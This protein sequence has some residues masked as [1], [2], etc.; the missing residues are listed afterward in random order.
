MSDSNSSAS[1][2]E[3]SYEELDPDV[4]LML[5]VREDDAMAFEQ[6]I[7]QYQGR[8]IRIL[9]HVV[10]R[11]DIAEDLAQDVFL[12]VY[13]ARKTYKP[14]ARFSTWLFRIAN[15]VASNSIRDR[16][17]RKE[18]QVTS[19]DSSDSKAM[20]METMAM[21]SSGVMPARN[22]DKS[23]RAAMVRQAIEA[24]GERQRMAL[25]L[26]KFEGL[27]YQEIADTME[28]STKAVKSLLMRARVNL[29]VL[30]QP[31]LDEGQPPQGGS[32]EGDE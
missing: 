21:A 10:G 3:M 16:S 12:R 1:Q 31:Y 29:K 4:G 9:E 11:K 18:V 7:Q 25:L 28:L 14:G 19:G 20:R 26:S 17:R 32:T 5:R 13:R 30:L 6:L 2:D 27:S 23:E 8:L 24:L 22:I 15:N